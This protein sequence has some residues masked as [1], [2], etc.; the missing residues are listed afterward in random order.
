MLCTTVIL[1][2]LEMLPKIVWKLPKNL[3]RAGVTQNIKIILFLFP[4]AVDFSFCN[5]FNICILFVKSHKQFY[6][7][8]KILPLHTLTVHIDVSKSKFVH[9]L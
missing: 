5:S 9:F 6:P 7:I 3:R 2:V 4:P 8:C 1:G